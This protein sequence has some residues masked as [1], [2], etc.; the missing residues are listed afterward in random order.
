M[1]LASFP[2]NA[3]VGMLFEESYVVVGAVCGVVDCGVA[4]AE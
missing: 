1:L 3:V 4:V 2:G